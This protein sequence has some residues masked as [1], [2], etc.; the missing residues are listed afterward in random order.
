[1]TASS[2]DPAF[3]ACAEI[4]RKEA[5]NFYYG[6]RLLPEPKRSA[7]YAV[8]AW[9]R[10]ADDIADEPGVALEIRRAALD[11]FETRTRALWSVEPV[12][13]GDPRET[14]VM[15][16]LQSVV[17][18]YAMQPNDFLAAIEGQRMDLAPRVYADFDEVT[19]Y[20]D[21]VASTVGR[22][23][24]D[25]WG[26]R[27]DVAAS[28]ELD[29]ETVIRARRLAT[30]RGVAFQLTNILRDISEDLARGRCYL[31]AD[32]LVNAGLDVAS[33]VRWENPEAC[34]RFMH[35]QCARAQRIFAE[36][37][38]LDGL[39]ARDSHAT[40]AAMSAIYS[41][42]LREIARRPARAMTQR[43]RLSALAKSWIALRAR[44]GFLGGRA[45]SGGGA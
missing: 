30:L 34:A 27:D 23:C 11:A 36:S 29:E 18:S 22:I 2:M 3:V 7:L 32:E 28:T 19:L 37:A 24:L 21:R 4:T 16:A 38:P 25:V 43:A 12:R 31:P 33:L 9:M 41:G 8:Y 26:L 44:F 13:G 39:V 10:I 40:I 15:S 17:R 6:L 45:F 35:V 5:K 1:M 14:A 42:I 20:C